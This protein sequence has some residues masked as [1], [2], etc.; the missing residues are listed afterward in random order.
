MASYLRAVLPLLFLAF[1]MIPIMQYRRF[2]SIHLFS[3]FLG[4]F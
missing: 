3:L 1:F 2:Y 4:D